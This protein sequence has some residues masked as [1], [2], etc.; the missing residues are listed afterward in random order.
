[1]NN[2]DL[3]TVKEFAER[4]GMSVQAIYKQLNNQLK[5]FSTTV[6]NKKYV[7]K[8]ALVMLE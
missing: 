4:G 3:L 8:K 2:N 1:M 5:E 6:E 7:N